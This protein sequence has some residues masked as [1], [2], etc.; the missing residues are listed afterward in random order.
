MERSLR[1]LQEVLDIDVT[2]AIFRTNITLYHTENLLS[3]CQLVHEE[4]VTTVT[5]TH[6]LLTGKALFKGCFIFGLLHSKLSETDLFMLIQLVF[7]V[8]FFKK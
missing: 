2:S 5:D 8:V 6:T 1:H 7:V 3:H 4:T